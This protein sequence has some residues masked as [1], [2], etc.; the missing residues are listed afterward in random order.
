MGSVLGA[1]FAGMNKAEGKHN[2]VL[3][4]EQYYNKN[5]GQNLVLN[6]V[7]AGTGVSFW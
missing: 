2:W 7:R 4:C 6:R 3:M 5:N 1:T